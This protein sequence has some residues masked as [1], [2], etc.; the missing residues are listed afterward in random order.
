MEALS[1]KT[2]SLGGRLTYPNIA[3]VHAKSLG[4]SLN[5]ANPGDDMFR[6]VLGYLQV[7]LCYWKTFPVPH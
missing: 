6:N 5:A 3:E 4:R 7:I 2:A 1:Q